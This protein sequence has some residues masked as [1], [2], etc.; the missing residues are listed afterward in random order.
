MS[1]II[2]HLLQFHFHIEY[3]NN[4]LSIYQNIQF[5]HLKYIP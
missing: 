4:Y 5:V 2:N 3:L 1:I